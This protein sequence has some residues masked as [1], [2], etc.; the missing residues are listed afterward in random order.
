MANHHSFFVWHE[1]S[2]VSFKDLYIADVFAS[3]DQLRA[4]FD[5]PRASFSFFFFKIFTDLGLGL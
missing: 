5:I 4:K 2:V 1:K 3:F